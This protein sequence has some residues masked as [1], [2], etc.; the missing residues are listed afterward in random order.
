VGFDKT[1]LAARA[2]LY[3]TFDWVQRGVPKSRSATMSKRRKFV[4]LLHATGALRA[5]LK[6]RQLASPPWLSILTYH[7]F[8]THGGNERFDDGVVDVTLESFER[9]VACLK[10]H[11]NLVG[12]DELCAFARGGKLPPNPVAITFD[13]GYLSAYEQALPILQRYGCKAIFF[14]AT[15]FITERRVFWWDR[16]AYLLRHSTR[17][18]IVLHRP[19][20]I[21]VDLKNDRSASIQRIL[22]ILNACSMA[23]REIVLDAIGR[24]ADVPWTREMDRAFADQLLMSWDQVRA[25]RKAGMDVQSHTRTHQ[26]LRTLPPDTLADEL[27]GSRADLVR[28]LGEPPRAVAYPVGNPLESASPIRAVLR[29]AGYE[30]G[31]TNGTG[32]TPLW[33]RVDPFNIRRQMVGHDFVEPYSL[34]IL[35]L[36][37]LAPTRSCHLSAHEGVNAAPR[38]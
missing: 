4:H 5:I 14:I 8:P 32:P 28:E 20:P 26:P 16:I 1:G 3:R 35:A 37:F 9:S 10:K 29:K 12:I 22:R 21:H 30:I 15:S 19:F 31:F 11:F 2:L 33:G 27:E 13:D 25:L 7:R 23:D 24:A 36:P 18:E 6:L 34:G 38:I 17:S